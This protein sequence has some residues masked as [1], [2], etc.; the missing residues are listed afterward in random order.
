MREYRYTPFERAEEYVPDTSVRFLFFV[1]P[2]Y[3]SSTLD[4][5]L[6]LFWLLLTLF[7]EGIES[8]GCY[9]FGP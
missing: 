5:Q 4:Q 6:C 2:S 1:E 9:S 8:H 7:A 3:F